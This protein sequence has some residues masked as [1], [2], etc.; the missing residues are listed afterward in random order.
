M[1]KERN[2]AIQTPDRRIN[3]AY[4][5]QTL[6]MPMVSAGLLMFRRTNGELEVFLGH[7][8]GPVWET[9]DEGAWTIPKGVIE[10]GESPSVA[11]AREFKEETGITAIGPFIELGT[12]VQKSGKTVHGWAFEG[13]VDPSTAFSNIIE[14][15][16]PP[17]SGRII[18]I[19]E[20]DRFEWLSV[21]IARN[22]LNPAQVTFVDR[23]VQLLAATE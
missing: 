12:I 13:D 19:P 18:E 5:C 22:R 17:R 15:T 10:R 6:S 20:L 23:L 14:I 8:G 7:P 16:W 3:R 9:R 4:P 11:A 1:Q 2:I 21:S